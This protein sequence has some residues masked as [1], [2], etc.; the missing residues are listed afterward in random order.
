MRGIEVPAWEDSLTEVVM[1][2]AGGWGATD[3]GGGMVASDVEME[4]VGAE[5]GAAEGGLMMR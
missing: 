4:G 1:V 2:N 5:G 3:D